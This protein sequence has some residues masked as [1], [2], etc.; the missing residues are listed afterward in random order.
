M[1]RSSEM[2]RQVRA[3]R[4]CGSHREER[5]GQIYPVHI[6]WPDLA[7]LSLFCLRGTL[8]K[9]TRKNVYLTAI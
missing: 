5:K 6:G 3:Q 1:Q 2:Q 9:L 4:Y 8:P 7:Q